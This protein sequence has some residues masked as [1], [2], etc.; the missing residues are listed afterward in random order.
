MPNDHM[1]KKSNVEIVHKHQFANV[2]V[3]LTKQTISMTT[4]ILLAADLLFIAAYLFSA[5][6]KDH[7][8]TLFHGSQILYLGLS[9]TLPG[10]YLSLKLL[11]GSATAALV[12]YT[13]EPGEKI[14]AFWYLAAI[15]LIYLAIDQMTQ[16]HTVWAHSAADILFGVTAGPGPNRANLLSHG[17]PL[18]TFYIAA[19]VAL[20]EQYK[21]ALCWLL[22]SA[23]VL[24]M[25]PLWPEITVPVRNLAINSPLS[26]FV[27]LFSQETFRTAWLEGLTLINS[28][29]VI[30][31]LAVALHEMQKKTVTYAWYYDI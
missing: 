14:S 21:R 12:I 19:I 27:E 3:R 25:G 13:F 11:A 29:L 9:S 23:V 16:F 1:Q 24:T 4:T 10:A 5:L 31:G 30:T 17:L 2:Q 22:P 7:A 6:P 20:R 26:S 8:L 15:V 18:A 28:T